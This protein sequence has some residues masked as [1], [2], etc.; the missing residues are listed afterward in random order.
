LR[1]SNEEFSISNNF[2]WV[3]VL[4]IFIS[5]LMIITVK[6]VRPKRYAE[7]FDI[8]DQEVMYNTGVSLEKAYYHRAIQFK[9]SLVT[10][11]STDNIDLAVVDTKKE[12]L[13]HLKREIIDIVAETNKEFYEYS[14]TRINPAKDNLIE[15]EKNLSPFYAAIFRIANQNLAEFSKNISFKE[16][17]ALNDHVVEYAILYVLEKAREIK[18]TPIGNLG[19]LVGSSTQDEHM[20]GA[21]SSLGFTSVGRY[22]IGIYVGYRRFWGKNKTTGEGNNV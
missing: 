19:S 14:L 17:M 8:L 20:L 15:V 12:L 13:P 6:F 3:A 7:E 11:V 18:N 21:C 16:A 1:S 2:A 22:G 4:G 5:L 9:G 10:K